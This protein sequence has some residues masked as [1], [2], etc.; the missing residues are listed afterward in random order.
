MWIRSKC[1]FITC[2][3]SHR[4]PKRGRQA[5]K[6]T[7]KKQ[8]S[9]HNHN[10]SGTI[11]RSDEISVFPSLTPCRTRSAFLCCGT[12]HQVYLQYLYVSTAVTQASGGFSPFSTTPSCTL[13]CLRVGV[14]GAKNCDFE[15]HEINCNPLP[16]IN[17]SPSCPDKRWLSMQSST[18]RPRCQRRCYPF[19]LNLL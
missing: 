10:W 16:S 11:Y 14:G 2:F 9:N 4:S 18:S 6:Q 15:R 19:R 1:T 17:F 12:N 7:K 13:F 5:N 3:L 8:P